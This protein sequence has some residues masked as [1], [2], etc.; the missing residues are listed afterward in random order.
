MI[1]PPDS[2]RTSGSLRGEKGKLGKHDQDR[3]EFT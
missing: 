3:C 1:D 2:R